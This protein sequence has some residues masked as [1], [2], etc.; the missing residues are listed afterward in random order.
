MFE[1]QTATIAACDFD[2]RIVEQTPSDG[3]FYPANRA[4]T[5]SIT[6]INSGTCA[7]ERNTALVYV[8]GES[9]D[10]QP[11]YFFI[12][13]RVNVGDEVTITFAGRTPATGGLVV[14]EWELRTPGQILIGEPF[15]ISVNVFEAGN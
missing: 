6:L 5:R 2:Y 12:R 8:D 7:W 11:P 14:G 9:F 3:E 15:T 10:A 1:M 13:Q 4:Y